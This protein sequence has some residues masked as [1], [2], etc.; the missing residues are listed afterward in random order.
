MRWHGVG[1]GSGASGVRVGGESNPKYHKG[2]VSTEQDDGHED[3]KSIVKPFLAPPGDCSVVGVCECGG[4][5]AGAVARTQERWALAK[6]GT[7]T[8]VVM[9]LIVTVVPYRSISVVQWKASPSTENRYNQ[10][11]T[12]ALAISTNASNTKWMKLRKNA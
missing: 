7:G 6:R 11:S 3:S 10:Q 5:G 2:L 8:G 1:S 9:N 12:I 4:G